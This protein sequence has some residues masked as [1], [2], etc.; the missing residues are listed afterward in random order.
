MGRESEGLGA[1][2]NTVACV[3]RSGG[4]YT[5]EYVERLAEGVK[6]HLPGADFWCLSDVPVAC[7]RVSLIHRWPGWWS[8]LEL[9]RPGLFTG[10]T[11]Y[12]DLDTYVV[13]D[14][15][16]IAAYPHRFTMLSDFYKPRF[17]ASGVM[18]WSG[19]WSR[20]YEAFARDPKRHMET[21]CATGRWGDQGFIAHHLGEDPARFQTL[22]PGQVLSRKVGGDRSDARI[23]C[24]HGRP[25]PHEVG[26]KY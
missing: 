25:R 26:W 8:K 9:F 4:P 15:T 1:P 3:L 16:E 17:P 14:L 6:R 11:L 19:D 5:A 20:L 24:S 13:G 7:R 10:P 2:A 22:F 21:Y 23:I 18:A 12:L